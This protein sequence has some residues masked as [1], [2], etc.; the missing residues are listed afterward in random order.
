MKKFVV[1]SLV[2]LLV[3]GLMGT[4]FAVPQPHGRWTDTETTTAL[5]NTGK[6]DIS[7]IRYIR[8]SDYIS[9][10]EQ[11]VVKWWLYNTG[12]RPVD[13]YVELIGVPWYLNARFFPGLH[14]KMRPGTRK[15]VALAVRMLLGTSSGVQD[16]NYQ[17][18]VKFTAIQDSNRHQTP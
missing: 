2:G 12:N 5:G 6:V 15:Q 10:S 3:L 13:V 1:M 18:D 11:L 8:F 7:T 14:F 16:R 17:I 4:A 9:P